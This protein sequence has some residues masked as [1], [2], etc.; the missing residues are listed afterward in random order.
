MKKTLTV[1]V[2]LFI[3]MIMMPLSA[4]LAET[5]NTNIKKTDEVWHTLDELDNLSYEETFSYEEL[6]KMFEDDGFSDNE[7]RLFIGDEPLI[8][9]RSNT[10]VR[11][12]LFKL[13]TYTYNSVYKLQPRITVGL[14]YSSSTA[15]SPTRIVSL[16]GAHIYTGLGTSCIFGGT[17]IYEL[18]AGNSFYYSFYG[19][20]YQS[21]DV[22]WSTG[23]EINIGD[24]ASVSGQISNG[25]GFI[26]NISESGRYYSTGLQSWFT[27]FW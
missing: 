10:I 18:E 21:G 12:S 23:V 25:S 17:M 3:L 13:D 15:T 27:Y 8:E 5:K 2:S 6:R 22:N 14:E 26:K 11:Y 9:S 19:D 7:I 20:L 4:S 1:I 24:D 16:K